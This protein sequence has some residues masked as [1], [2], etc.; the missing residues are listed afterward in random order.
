MSAGDTLLIHRLITDQEFN[1]VVNSI[2]SECDQQP[3]EIRGTVLKCLENHGVFITGDE[4]VRSAAVLT[5]M[6]TLVVAEEPEDEK[7]KE[8]QDS[9]LYILRKAREV[10]STSRGEMLKGLELQE[11]TKMGQAFLQQ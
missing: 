6:L 7:E 11:K 2:A 5:P 9:Q 4:K 8:Q 3:A 10:V 1:G